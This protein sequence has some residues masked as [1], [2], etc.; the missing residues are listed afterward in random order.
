MNNSENNDQNGQAQENDAN[1]SNGYFQSQPQLQV[2]PEQ[3][4][5][6]QPQ[7][8]APQVP[9]TAEIPN[10]SAVQP[11]KKKIKPIVIILIV[12][13]SIIV[14]AG[15]IFVVVFFVSSLGS[16]LSS[17]NN[18]LEIKSSTNS[19]PYKPIASD[20]SSKNF[21]SYKPTSKK[22]WEMKGN[23]AVTSSEQTVSF[24]LSTAWSSYDSF[25]KSYYN[26]DPFFKTTTS[27]GKQAMFGIYT[28]SRVTS[29]DGNILTSTW[30][31]TDETVDLYKKSVN[32]DL[33][34]NATATKKIGDKNWTILP[35]DTDAQNKNLT[36]Y[37]AVDD[38][39]NI[40]DLAYIAEVFTPSSLSEDEYF[41]A[42]KDIESALSTL[43]NKID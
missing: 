10:I 33:K 22:T 25:S 35:S 21:G 16:N 41:D 29:K 38:D 37:V 1:N 19:G 12:V 7:S 34:F 8:A 20:I 27:S 9:L 14:L 6:F 31:T 5:V 17:V 36:T 28:M 43:S 13:G 4:E 39:D 26:G 11:A 18:T 23:D 42:I 3:P 2:Q 24:D 15:S 40:T 30:M 32:S